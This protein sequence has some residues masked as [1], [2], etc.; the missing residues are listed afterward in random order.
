M[1]ARGVG[2]PRTGEISMNPLARGQA[3]LGNRPRRNRPDMVAP[4]PSPG[5]TGELSGRNERER[6]WAP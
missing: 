6:E 1:R 2:G 4:V 3:R 5:A